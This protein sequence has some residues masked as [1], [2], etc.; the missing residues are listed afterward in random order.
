MSTSLIAELPAR[1][2][3]RV[4]IVMPN[5]GAWLFLLV[6]LSQGAARKW[7]FHHRRHGKLELNC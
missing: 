7:Q 2:C 3:C 6:A 1:T 5:Q 4:P